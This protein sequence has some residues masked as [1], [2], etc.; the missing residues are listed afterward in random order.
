M[1]RKNDG[2]EEI[3]GIMTLWLSMMENEIFDETED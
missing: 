1:V 2:Q 3:E